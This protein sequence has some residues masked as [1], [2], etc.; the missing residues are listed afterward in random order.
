MVLTISPP[1]TPRSTSQ[2]STVIKQGENRVALRGISWL[3][4]QQIL[5]D[6]PQSRAARLTYDRGILEITMP[7]ETTPVK[8]TF[9]EIETNESRI[10]LSNE[11]RIGL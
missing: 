1:E 4:Y 11:S 10:G 7:L 5:N 3:V 8:V 6:L 2:F 9:S